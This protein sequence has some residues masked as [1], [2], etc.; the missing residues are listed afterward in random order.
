MPIRKV[1][2]IIPPKE[3]KTIVPLTEVSKKPVV[4][5][6]QVQPSKPVVSERKPRVPFKISKKIHWWP[7]LTIA[8]IVCLVGASYIFIKPKAEISIWPK[9]SPFNVKTQV[10]VS[11]SQKEGVIA[12]KVKIQECSDSQEFPATGVKS[13]GAKATG[14]IRVYNNYATTPQ[15][16]VANTRFVSDGG[17]LFRTPQKI[18]I[19]GARYEG[20]KLIPGE[21]DVVVG[22]GETGEEYNIGPST[23]SLPALAARYTAFYAKSFEAMTGGSKNQTPQVTEADL[24]SAQ[25]S[26]SAS[27]LDNCQKTLQASLA[28]ED[29]VINEEAFKSEIVESDP[30]VRVGQS[31][32]KFT[33]NIKAKAM[34]MVFQKSDVENFA[35]TYV[36]GQVP[37][38]NQLDGNS[39]TFSY[40][41]KSI[42]VDKGEIILN[43][44]V[45]AEIYSTIDD[46][47]I[48]EAI[49]SQS[50]NEV[51]ASLKQ[52]SEISDFQVRLWPFWV[53]KTSSEL[54]N[55]TIK[56]RLD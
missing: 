54:K 42:N 37:T 49:K 52:F 5:P 29:Y 24:T 55:M 40:S 32:N 39:V 21:L 11:T 38:G 31:V 33:L 17:K 14:T 53:N 28:P 19:P 2:D 4:F 6:K 15:I 10:A 44:E 56:L 1:F 36:A 27:V 7:I 43:V 12:G 18:T 35:K 51:T 13:L 41:P 8:A 30:L 45:S 47:S 20:S 23:F 46:N 9:K 34:V 25:K 22:A 26:L 3:Y 48:K 16:L 50:L